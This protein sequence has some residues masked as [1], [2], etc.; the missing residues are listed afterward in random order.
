M[1]FSWIGLVSISSAPLIRLLFLSMPSMFLCFNQTNF[2]LFTNPFFYFWNKWGLVNIYLVLLA[3]FVICNFGLLDIFSCLRPTNQKLV[4][5]LDCHAKE[6]IPLMSNF[7]LP[8]P[9]LALLISL[10]KL[11]LAYLMM[12][13]FSGILQL[14]IMQF[15]TSWN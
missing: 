14:L 4:E 1:P 3:P 13:V 7:G 15:L 11:F 8:L 9:H 10:L 5:A 2:I 12:L 6:L